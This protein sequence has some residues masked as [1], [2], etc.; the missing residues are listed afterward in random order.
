MKLLSPI[1]TDFMLMQFFT[2]NVP[3]S[4]LQKQLSPMLILYSEMNKDSFR[5]FT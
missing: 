4:T 3:P 5:S 2:S 1:V